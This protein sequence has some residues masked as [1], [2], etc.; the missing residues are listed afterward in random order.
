MGDPNVLGV[1]RRARR[2]LMGPGVWCRG[3]SYEGGLPPSPVRRCLF[4]AIKQAAGFDV[5]SDMYAL[6]RLPET[7]RTT[8]GADIA[9][10]TSWNDREGRRF[11]DVL[12][13]LEQAIAREKWRPLYEQ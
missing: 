4:E 5:E 13:V 3:G 6:R 12:D 2:I 10:I 7:E 11:E 1:L 9:C 8:L